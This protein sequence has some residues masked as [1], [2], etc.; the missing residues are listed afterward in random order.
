MAVTESA[1]A[2]TAEDSAA[3]R[4]QTIRP[5]RARRSR[6]YLA[7]A[8]ALII[9][10]GMGSAFI[11]ATASHTEQVLVVRH[12]V[13]RGEFITPT[14]LGS[15]G[16]AAGQTTQGVPAANAAEVLGKVAT[17]DLPKGSLITGRSF[18]GSLTVPAGQALVGLSLKPSQLPAQ[19]LVAGD[20]VVIVPVAVNGS[21]VSTSS[22]ADS[23]V[24]SEAVRDT[25]S[26][27]TIVDVYVSQTI[28]ADLTSR[29]S[30]GAV[31]IF[32]TASGK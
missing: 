26:G 11:Y 24:V 32:L 31:A 29:A 6:F 28:A 12:D 27:T 15:I 16:V 1:F 25:A 5:V 3:D 10:G 9:A 13:E 18:A 7:G 14:D 21:S 23:G 8:L 20:R 19:P 2:V 30:V 22:G 4:P 17:V